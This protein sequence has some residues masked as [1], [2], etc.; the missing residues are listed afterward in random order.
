MKGDNKIIKGA[1]SLGMGAFFSKLL[2]AF[3][4]IFLTFIVGGY[5]L[6]LYQMIFPVYALFFAVLL[7][8]I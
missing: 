1:L 7:F 8:I 5:G 4:R 2:G 6:G 3:Y